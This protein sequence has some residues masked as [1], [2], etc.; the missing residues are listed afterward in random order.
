MRRAVRVFGAFTLAAI[1]GFSSAQADMSD[2]VA[3]RRDLTRFNNLLAVTGAG[4]VLSGSGRHTVFAPIDAAFTVL[5]EGEYPYLYTQNL[6]G[7]RDTAS[8]IA[9]N[10]IVEGNVNIEDKVKHSG[11]LYAINGRFLPIGES[12]RGTYT[13]DGHRILRTYGMAD[14]TLYLIDG[15]IARSTELAALPVALPPEEVVVPVGGGAVSVPR[16]GAVTV[17]E[18]V[19]PGVEQTTTITHH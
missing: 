12:S 16:G 7:M 4:T 13:V 1:A 18:R 8:H 6:P 17:H 14:G 19:A 11:G 2:T 9:Q 5:P 3:S 15:V 10:H